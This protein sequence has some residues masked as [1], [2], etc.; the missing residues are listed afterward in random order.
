MLSPDI[1]LAGVIN[2]LA[3]GAIYVL[4]AVGLTL[5]Y[6]VLHIINFAH[7]SL[8]MLGMYAVFFL[9]RSAKIDPYMALPLVVAGIFVLGYV[10]CR[11]VIAGSATARMRRSCR[12][13]SG[14]RSSSTTSRCSCSPATRRPS[15]SPMPARS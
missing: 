9:F 10:L 12:S 5:I 3:A 1:L 6:D 11:L 4:V 14:C 13:R 7:G 15:T 8:L 2:G